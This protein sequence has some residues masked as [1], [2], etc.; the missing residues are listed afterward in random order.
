[1]NL[2]NDITLKQMEN[3]ETTDKLKK[4]D[5][6]IGERYKEL[7][8]IKVQIEIKEQKLKD[9]QHQR[10]SIINYLNHDDND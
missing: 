3:S 10:Q 1:M 8:F 5:S 2:I 9:L 6:E 7:Q 4:L